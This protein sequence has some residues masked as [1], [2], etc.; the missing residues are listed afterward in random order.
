[1]RFPLALSARL[2]TILLFLSWA[3]LLLPFADAHATGT[4][5]PTIGTSTDPSCP[6]PNAPLP[7]SPPTDPVSS[8]ISPGPT[9]DP[10]AYVLQNT[11]HVRL[12]DL[13]ADGLKDLYV[14]ATSKA[15]VGTFAMLQGPN[16]TFTLIASPTPE[17]HS[18]GK[19]GRITD[20]DVYRYDLSGDGLFD[21]Q[22]E[23]VN[24]WIPNAPD[25][26]VL[27]TRFTGKAPVKIVHNDQ[28]FI[29]FVNEIDSVLTHIDDFERVYRGT[30][31]GLITY[32]IPVYVGNPYGYSWSAD[33][34]DTGSP[35]TYYGG[36]TWL[37]V[38]QEVCIPG[39]ALFAPA[40][41]LF[42]SA[43]G[44]A[45]G[46]VE[47]MGQ[48]FESGWL[49][50]VLIDIKRRHPEAIPK[51]ILGA[52]VLRATAKA[53][54]SYR[55]VATVAAVVLAADDASV[56]GL[57][58]DVLIPAFGAYV[59]ASFVLD[60]AVAVLDSSINAVNA[61]DVGPRDGSFAEGP[62]PDGMF[63]VK[64]AAQMTDT[65]Y[66]AAARDFAISQNCK[67]GDPT[68]A[69]KSGPGDAGILRENLD[70][71]GCTCPGE[72]KSAAHH[73]VTKDT[74]P[75]APPSA[76]VSQSIL[77]RCRINI[78][79]AVNGVCLPRSGNE[80]TDASKHAGREGNIHLEPAQASI[81][82]KLQ[83]ALRQAGDDP[84]DPN[85]NCSAAGE[86]GVRNVLRTIAKD[87]TVGNVP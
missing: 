77:Q 25:L 63:A 87:L 35:Y 38:Q 48:L 54:R 6:Q 8:K 71:A 39:S 27:T 20:I 31:C 69:Q 5:C 53:V 66:R 59:G 47:A 33:F 29:N 15:A 64:P 75:K 28:D 44:N 2:L 84:S 32:Y 82:M 62:A 79:N 41:Q 57:V 80:N 46:A 49:D 50:R 45:T 11:Y 51:I 4:H 52:Q 74:G 12:A 70:T 61:A 76:I 30:V 9:V 55:R 17:Q 34:S 14:Y 43:L 1:V 65:E 72:G 10:Y 86:A 7:L 16:L 24:K 73:M 22:F 37:L 83:D 21:F 60:G 36:Y 19:A 40:G 68:I 67:A 85:G 81:K 13:N 18:L 26:T 42:F 58:D 3:T 56:V 78:D 23:N